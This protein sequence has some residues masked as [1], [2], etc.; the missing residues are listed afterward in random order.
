[1][2]SYVC[3]E[4]AMNAVTGHVRTGQPSAW[5]EVFAQ[6]E[7]LSAVQSS[8]SLCRPLQLQHFLVQAV[9]SVS[10]MSA[11]SAMSLVFHVTLCKWLCEVVKFLIS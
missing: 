1:M 2:D 3:C 9:S 6:T 10:A 4:V 8:C 11:M 5:S 7:G